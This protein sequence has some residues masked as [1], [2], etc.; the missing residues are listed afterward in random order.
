MTVAV[1]TDSAC[2]LPV[3]IAQTLGV[4]VV[5]LTIRFGDEEFVDRVD[6][7]PAQFWAK[8]KASKDLP[9]TA[10]PSPGAFQEAYQRARDAGYDSAIVLTLS[11]ALSATH[12]SATLAAFSVPGLTVRVV[13]TQAVTMAQGI[14]AIDVAE[15]ARAGAGLDDLV[16]FAEAQ[17]DRLGVCAML[18]TLDHL[19]KGGRVGGARALLGQVLSIKPL[20]EL[21]DGV[22]AEAGRQRT[23]ARALGAIA[24]AARA[25]APLERLALVHGDSPSVESFAASVADIETATPLIISDIGPVVGTHAGPGIIG[26][27]WARA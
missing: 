20:L 19:V 12:Q 23:T 16:A 17:R 26:L 7:S 10:A 2:D 6:L 18:G 21:K 11:A 27:C 13:D 3:E 4:D 22:V 5:S 14:L 15:R 1:I 8:C 24:A 25:R 9:E